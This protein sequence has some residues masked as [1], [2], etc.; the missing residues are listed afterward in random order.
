MK[1]VCAVVVL[2]AI[3]L[4]GFSQTQPATE[5]VV[6][7]LIRFAGTVK[8][9]TGRVAI[10]FSLHKSDRDDAA[11]WTE[12]QNVQLEDGKYT[13]LLGAT[14]AE[15][16]P[17]DLFTSGEAQWL[18]IRVE[19]RPEQRVLLV[20]VPY[21]LK[22]AEA[23]TLAGH[24]ASEF[25]T[26]E[27]V[28][29]L[30]QQQLQQQQTAPTKSATTKKDAGAKG[31]VLTS[32]ATNFTD[33][34][35][36][37]VVLVTQKGAGNGLVSNSISA[38]GVSGTTA[39]SAG[40]G[41]SGANT[42]ATGL[43]IGVRGSTV[44][45]SGISVYGT[46]GGTSGTATGVKGI[47]AAPNGYGVF[48]QNTATTG[49]AIGFR[50]TTA[51]TSGIGIYGTSTATTGS[52]VGVRASVAS[53]SGTSA[54]LQNTAGGKLLSGLSG[55]G[56]SEVFSVL[57]NG[58]LTAGAASFNG[59]VTFASGQTF[60][61]TLPNFGVQ[62]MNGDLILQ[63]LSSPTPLNAASDSTAGTY[64]TLFNNSGSGSGWQF[65]TT[66]T[67][68]SQGAGHLLFYGGPNPQSVIIQ[69]PVSAGDV[70]S[71]FLHSNTTVRAETGLSLGG[72]ATLKVDAPGI[73][74]GQF[75]VQNGTMS[76]NQDV[77]VS[78]NSRM[79]F[80][81]Y[82]FGDTGDSGLLGSTLGYIHPE[83]DIVVTGIFGSTNNKGVGNCGNDAIITLE[84]PG[85][86][87][88]PKVNLDIIEGIPTWSNMFLSVPFNSVYD[89]QIVL[90]QNSGGCAPF[91]HTTNNPVIS[92]VYYMK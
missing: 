80:T 36:N 57:G 21:A 1:F 44:A 61:G 68:A 47:S 59:P 56:S 60:P 15:G 66:G 83:R 74:G 65:V 26:T 17:F 89:L 13:I 71:S 55:S 49:L 51:S 84:Q 63:G 85:N 37:Q 54:I 69:A 41:V 38:N 73:V 29:N 7:H 39:S 8:G 19:G 5:V 78:S 9:A 30:V 50:G 86:P 35:A 40:V 67:G 81:G 72:N 24:S 52:T 18:S 76:I 33:N 12:T 11:L 87:S 58:N 64:F 45:D 91:S 46:A 34:T 4:V 16:L 27:K 43:A 32:T 10:T 88:T 25:V 6:P 62:T 48:G 77:P 79:V 2:L 3:T 20:S 14:K 53:V 75:V 70:T 28:T 31:N 82:L 42:A 23:E 90:T 92:V 22:A